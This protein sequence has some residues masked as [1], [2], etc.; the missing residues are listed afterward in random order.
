MIC[1]Q[2]ESNRIGYDAWVDQ[3]GNVI[4]GPYD[5]CQCMDCGSDNIIEERDYQC[6]TGA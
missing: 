6:Q 5:N 3:D 2:C 1:E 4:G